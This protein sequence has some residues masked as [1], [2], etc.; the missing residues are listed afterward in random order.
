MVK[1]GYSRNV[2]QIISRYSNLSEED[3][4]CLFKKNGVYAD[5]AAWAKFTDLALLGIGATFVLAGIVFFFAYNWQYLHKF[6][7]LGIIQMMVNVPVFSILVFKPRELVKNMLLTASCVLVGVLFAVFGQIYQTGAD[8]YD[9]FLGWTLFIGLWALSARFEALWLIFLVLINITFV[10]Y[11]QQAGPYRLE[12][13]LFVILFC[14]N[15]FTVFILYVLEPTGKVA[16]WLVRAV[17]LG[18]V[19]LLT[20]GLLAGV[21]DNYPAEW[22][23]AMGLCLITY[24]TGIYYSVKQRSMYLLCI[25]PISLIVVLCA[26]F[27]EFT[28]AE[29]GGFLFVSFFIVS[30]ITLLVK[31]LVRL[32]RVWNAVKS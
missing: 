11:V 13:W 5:R 24:T 7:K 8:A 16:S 18:A 20:I 32:N 15:T 12:K 26:M 1:T 9:L 29:M 19:V 22:F 27:L 3:V 6:V 28:D 10:L 14:F 31:E 2:I 25:L 4:K 21:M 30:C 17:V 23:V